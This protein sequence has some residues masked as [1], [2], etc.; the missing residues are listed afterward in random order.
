MATEN[1]QV[2]DVSASQNQKEVTINAAHNLLDRAMNNIVSVAVTAGDTN[3]LTT[4]Q[5]RENFV[6]ELTGTPGAVFSV[7]MPDTNRRTL[8]IVNNA[9]DVC[10][11]RNSAAGGTGQ[12]I[13][14]AGASSIFHYDGTDFFDLLSLTEI[15]H[16]GMY[17]SGNTDAFVVAA[18]DEDHSYHTNGLVAADLEG[19]AFDAGGGGTS[20]A[21]T[22]I[23][24][25]VDAGVDIKVTTGTV[26]G[27]A[28]G[29]IVSQT[30]LADAAYV[31]VFK[32]KAIIDT[33]NYEVAAVFTATGTGT[34]DEAATLECL[35][36]FAG[37]YSL[38]C[39]ISGKPLT[40]ND[41]FEFKVFKD[42]AAVAG[43]LAEQ[44][45]P[46]T[47]KLDNVAIVAPPFSVAAGD[48]IS[49]AVRNDDGSAN[50][51]LQ[52]M[53]MSLQRL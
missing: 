50:I 45:F 16:A 30:N 15:A 24:D 3:D 34:M 33:T 40:N 46:S 49:L 8:A 35:T 48:K 38:S 47:L 26:H 21:I 27:L 7:D 19:W 5:A 28:V 43:A 20:H 52:S 42:A 12:P 17:D 10:T 18:Q 14:A 2:P 23:A 39:S 29:G 32:V 44:T 4:T 22:V 36:G 9:D 25:G 41:E 51:I 53:S 1:L 6:V 13:I 37:V 11:V 31:G